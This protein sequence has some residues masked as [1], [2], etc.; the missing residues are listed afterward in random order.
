MAHY[1]RSSCGACPKTNG[2]SIGRLKLLHNISSGFIDPA[3]ASPVF[4]KDARLQVYSL[5][6]NIKKYKN[7]ENHWH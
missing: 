3:E 1:K 2:T 6:Y 4:T 7:T 5:I